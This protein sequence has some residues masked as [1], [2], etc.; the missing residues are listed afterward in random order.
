VEGEIIFNAL[1]GLTGETLEERI[2]KGT[3]IIIQSGILHSMK[4]I[5]PTI[6]IE[7]R[8]TIFNPQQPDT[9]DVSTYQEYLET[10]K[11]RL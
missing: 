5:K 7:Y 6:Y 3:E 11:N 8:S 2:T 10:F 4:I 9:Y 1:N